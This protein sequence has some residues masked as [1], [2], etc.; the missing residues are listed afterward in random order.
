MVNSA[1]PVGQRDGVGLIF[2]QTLHL[3]ARRI[4]QSRFYVVWFIGKDDSAPA[5]FPNG[6]G[7][8]GMGNRVVY[9]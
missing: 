5:F 1:I 3:D 6:G 8:A 2:S 4:I 7:F 9:E